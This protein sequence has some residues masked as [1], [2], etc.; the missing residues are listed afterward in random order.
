MRIQHVRG[1]ELSNW[2]SSQHLRDFPEKVIVTNG[3]TNT[4]PFYN[5]EYFIISLIFIN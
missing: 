5:Y 2:S 1:F 3:V 4:P